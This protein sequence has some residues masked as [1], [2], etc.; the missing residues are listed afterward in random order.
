MRKGATVARGSSLAKLLQ[1]GLPSE[2]LMS[3]GSPAGY[4]PQ[5]VSGLP[6]QI[7]VD[8]F[9]CLTN[10]HHAQAEALYLDS[11]RSGEM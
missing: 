10:H 9:R 6:S 3:T 4:L 5:L 2:L 1:P 8:C 7:A 11:F